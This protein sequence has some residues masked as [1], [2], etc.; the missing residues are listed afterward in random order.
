MSSQQNE[1]HVVNRG[2]CGG[3]GR[4][5]CV[6]CKCEAGK[7]CTSVYVNQICGGRGTILCE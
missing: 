4:V 3:T 1:L 7:E 6:P 2:N 5:V